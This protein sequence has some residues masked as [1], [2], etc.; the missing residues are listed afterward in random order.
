MVALKLVGFVIEDHYAGCDERSE[1]AGILTHKFVGFGCIGVSIALRRVWLLENI[2]GV[3]ST[4]WVPKVTGRR[5]WWARWA[6][7]PWWAG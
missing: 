5:T 4:P 3:R 6:R 7:W 1:F 2:I